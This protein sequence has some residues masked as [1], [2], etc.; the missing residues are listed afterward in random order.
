[1]SAVAAPYY[2]T[3]EDY[4]T[5]EVKSPTRHEYV[6]G[7]VYAMA[8][9]T[10]RHN[11]IVGSVY[12]A[13]RAHLRG[14]KCR[15]FIENVRV[16]ISLAERDAFYYP[17]IL[18]TCDP[19]DVDPY[20]KR[21]PKLIIEVLSDSTEGTDRREKFWN[22]TATD[23][24]EEYVLI[25]QDRCEVM[26]FRRSANWQPQTHANLAD[27]AHLISIDLSLPLQVI[28]EGIDLS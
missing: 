26:I 8:G 4:L 5:D 2:L 22:Y 12:A 15:A 3:V 1:M 27:D 10:D 20:Q 24:L 13:I 18:V 9:E 21:F 14:G 7:M 28:Y 23:S 25:A 19:R 11:L 6:A 17:D 16:Q